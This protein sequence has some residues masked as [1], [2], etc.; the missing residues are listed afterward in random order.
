MTIPFLKKLMVASNMR[1]DGAA[2]TLELD[3]VTALILH[4]L[5]KMSDEESVGL[6][7]AMDPNRHS[8]SGPDTA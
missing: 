2:P 1:F 7:I 5:P 3:D 6:M 8:S 4:Y